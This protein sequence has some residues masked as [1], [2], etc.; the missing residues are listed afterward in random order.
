MD[1]A[2]TDR[3][4][5]VPSALGMILLAA[6]AADNHKLVTSFQDADWFLL[7]R[8]DLLLVLGFWLLCGLQ[9][10]W[11]RISVI[12]AFVAIIAYDLWRA[13]A[14]AGHP[15]CS[16]FGRVAVDP[17]SL[18]TGDLIIVMALLR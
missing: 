5:A 13:R 7:L 17:G 12:A 18:M 3:W 16:S 1:H 8:A 6:G 15:V 10:R 11:S 4:S 14:L 2:R 9:P